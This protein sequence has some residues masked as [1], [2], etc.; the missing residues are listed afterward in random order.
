MARLLLGEDLSLYA[1]G[2]QSGPEPDAPPEATKAEL[3]YFDQR[4]S[5]R[6]LQ[7]GGDGALVWNLR[8]TIPLADGKQA[9]AVLQVAGDGTLIWTQPK[10]GGSEEVFA[11]DLL[12]VLNVGQLFV[13]PTDP[14]GGA[15]GDL[16]VVTRTNV[17]EASIVPPSQVPV[18][19][20]AATSATPTVPVSW[21]AVNTATAYRVTVDGAD[22]AQV[23]TLTLTLTLAQGAHTITVRG[24]NSGGDGPASAPKTCTV[25]NQA[26]PPVTNLRVTQVSPSTIDV[27]WDYAS[28]PADFASYVVT[29]SVGTVT[30]TGTTAHVSA[31]AADI[32]VSITVVARDTGGLDSTPVSTTGRTSPQPPPAAPPAPTNFRVTRVGYSSAD[33]AWDAAPGATRYEVSGDGTSFGNVGAVLSWGWA[34]LTQQTGYTLYV[35]GVNAGGAGPAAAVSFTTL[36][37]VAYWV[38]THQDRT[39]GYGAEDWSAAGIG[40][41]SSGVLFTNDNWASGANSHLYALDLNLNTGPY[42]QQGDRWIVFSVGLFVDYVYDVTGWWGY[43]G[44]FRWNAYADGLAAQQQG[45]VVAS[46]GAMAVGPNEVNNAHDG[47][48]LKHL[49]MSYSAGQG[50]PGWYKLREFQ[51]HV[52]QVTGQT[53]VYNPA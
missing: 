27:A 46:G 42:S 47:V 30:V 20:V 48:Q 25:Q 44:T 9:G 6:V 22:V 40:Y 14:V 12:D 5:G 35:R 24:L 29:A 45:A 49:Q 15:N 2:T 4:M 10:P 21:T 41:E 18:V 37:Q 53:P 39:I 50:S 3:P 26:P 32:A 33:F 36:P 31:L 16:W 34:G 11:T 51:I 28:P 52:R 13:G 38:T 43:P 1:D 8:G 23:T 17:T 7:I 19:T